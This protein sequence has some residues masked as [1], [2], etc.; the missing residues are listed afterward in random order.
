MSTLP[1]FASARARPGMTV[2]T[3]GSAARR[4]WLAYMAWRIERWAIPRLRAMSERQLR[5]IEI[6]R[7]QIA[8]ALRTGAERGLR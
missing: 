8:S 4:L 6:V 1:A 3:A 7:S 2:H 5:D